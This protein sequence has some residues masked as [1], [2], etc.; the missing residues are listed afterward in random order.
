MS[1]H[2][3]HSRLYEETG[4]GRPPPS[5]PK[6]RPVRMPVETDPD[7]LGAQRRAVVRR[8]GRMST[9]LTDGARGSGRQKLGA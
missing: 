6:P 7:T 9:I 8:A 2:E 3:F 5:A 1:R 4:I